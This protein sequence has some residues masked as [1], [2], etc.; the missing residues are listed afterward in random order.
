MADSS[1]TKTLQLE[2]RQIYGSTRLG[3]ITEEVRLGE[4][5]SWPNVLPTHDTTYATLC[6]LESF[7]QTPIKHI[8]VYSNFL[9]YW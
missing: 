2:Q 9:N 7:N 4:N 5:A 8:K 3:V 1:G 6:A